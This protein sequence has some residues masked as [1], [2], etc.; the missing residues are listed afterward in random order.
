MYDILSSISQI[1]EGQAMKD[2]NQSDPE[3][4]SAMSDFMFGNWEQAE[5]SLLKLHERYPKSSF[6]PLILGN[7]Y[8]ST[9]RL[10]QSIEYYR[11][12]LEMDPES[13]VA[14]YKLGV[15]YF[16]KGQLQKSLE[17]F[18][19]V[20]EIKTQGH[21]MASYFIGLINF[22]L[23]RDDASSAAFSQ[24]HDIAPESM[25]SNF[26]LAQLKLKRNEFSEAISLLEELLKEN[27]DLSEGH[28]ML[29]QAHYGLHQNSE[30]IRSFRRV[31][32]INPDDQRAK[33]KLTLMTDGEW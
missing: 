10:R 9:G 22:F 27:P 18:N 25:I 1:V 8:Y 16:R 5:E 24:F 21:A 19:R 20:L 13:G 31:L 29:G 32:E 2:L 11:R 7:V 6:V 17:A 23:G 12:S 28:Y 26:F 30:S 4:I 3:Y 15:T 14:N 33:S